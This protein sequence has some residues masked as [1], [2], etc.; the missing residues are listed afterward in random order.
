MDDR[1]RRILASLFAQPLGVARAATKGLL[2]FVGV[3]RDALG[4]EDELFIVPVVVVE[5]GAVETLNHLG[6]A[7]A[8]FD[9]LEDAEGDQG[10]ATF[11]V[12]AVHVDDEGDVGEGLGEVEGVEAD[13]PDVVPPADVEGGSGRLPRGAGVDV[14]EFEGDV[15]DSGA[16]VGDAELAGARGDGLA[17]L[18]AHVRD[19]RANLRLCRVHILVISFNRLRVA[20]QDT[21]GMLERA[22]TSAGPLADHLHSPNHKDKRGRPAAQTTVLQLVLARL[23]NLLIG[24]RCLEPPVSASCPLTAVDA[25]ARAAHRSLRACSGTPRLCTAAPDLHLRSNAAVDIDVSR[26]HGHDDTSR[27]DNMTF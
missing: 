15:A 27:I 26:S 5:V 23:H 21:A 13:L 4:L 11:V 20:E 14:R 2:A 17:V 18:A 1:F 12:Q 24:L 8:G 22:R 3:T 7:G 19:A 10:A 25:A 9:G 6:G 16:P